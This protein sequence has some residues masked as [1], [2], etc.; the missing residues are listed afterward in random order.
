MI[1]RTDHRLIV[2]HPRRNLEVGCGIGDLTGGKVANRDLDFV[3]AFFP[4]GPGKNRFRPKVAHGGE[5]AP[6]RTD[7][8][9]DPGGSGPFGGNGQDHLG[10][11]GGRQFGRRGHRQLAGGGVSDANEREETG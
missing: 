7:A 8:E 3:E 4:G 5:V 1:E 9:A 10:S 2:L 11:H 6:R